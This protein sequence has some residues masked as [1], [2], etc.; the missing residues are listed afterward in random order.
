VGGGL[1]RPGGHVG[2]A[3]LTDRDGG[4]RLR[5]ETR[6]VDQVDDYFGT[7]VPD[8]YRWLEDLEGDETRAWV[9]A[10]NAVTQPFLAGLPG[11]AAIAERLE[12]LW[13]FERVGLPVKEGGTYFFTR[14]DGLQD[15][16]VLCCGEA[17]DREARVL[18]DANAFSEDATVSLA[19]FAVSPC[20]TK[21]AYAVSDGGSDWTVWR[22]RDVATGADLLDEIR[23]TK[24]SV[25]S[26]ERNGSAF[27]YSRYPRRPDGWGDDSAA[28]AVYRHRLGTSQAEDVR[29]YALPES[30]RHNP[31]AAV[32]E[33]GRFLVLSIQEGYESNAVHLLRLDVPGARPERLLDAW[34]ALYGFVG[35]VG[36]ELYFQTTLDAPRSRVVA[37]HADRPGRSRWREVIPEAPEPLEAASLVGG[38]LVARYLEDASSRVRL[39]ELDGTPAGEVA[40]P[41]IGTASG[42]RGKAGDP[43]TFFAFTS[44][45]APTCLYAHDVVSGRARLVQRPELDVDESRYATRQVFVTSRDGTRVPMFVVHRGDLPRDGARPTLLYGYGGFSVS[46][47][48]AF[49]VSRLVWLE[50]G[51]VLA[52]PNL[53]GGGEYGEEWHSAGTRLRKQ[54]VFDDFIA[55]A[56]WLIA[57]GYTAPARLGIQGG[58]NGGLLVGAAITQRPELFGAVVAVVGVLD[59]LRYHLPSANARAW[60]S[61]YGLSENE[62]EFRALHAYS[63]YHRLVPD[64]CYPATLVATG[65]HDDRVVPWH[66]YK[67]GAALQAAQGCDAPILLRVETRAGHGAGTPTWMRIE[68][69]ADRLAFLASRL[70][71]DP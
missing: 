46:L 50:R 30:P 17:V 53:R 44:F 24:F 51:G 41:G 23:L 29:V 26:W 3:G 48:P 8:P 64:T 36:D 28:V 70:G 16:D 1:R 35:N 9:A 56:E 57:E 25:A 34:D 13:S 62:A 4:G 19:S 52:I 68:A 18:I 61:D 27:Y 65:D 66:S 11:R 7:P 54:N 22:V 10:Q 55:A 49:D 39:F 38:R 42:F 21:V 14:N 59:M 67:F 43:E 5:P 31:Y 32:S 37:I 15:Q 60:C 20:G 2:G 12:R 40:L 47:T 33:D 45:T 69:A 6:R 58:S 71:L 63:P